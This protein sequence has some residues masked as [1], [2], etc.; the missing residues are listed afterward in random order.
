M[1]SGR[2]KDNRS[3]IHLGLV[4]TDFPTSPPEALID[5]SAAKYIYD[6]CGL[7]PH[8]LSSSTLLEL[9]LTLM[10]CAPSRLGSTG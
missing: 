3:N 9:I 4:R 1:R 6:P 7:P 5:H 8:K 2:E 10:A